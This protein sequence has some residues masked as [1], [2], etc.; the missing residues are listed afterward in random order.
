MTRKLPPLPKPDMNIFMYE[1]FSYQQGDYMGLTNP[2]DK[3]P[4]LPEAYPQ[5]IE[6]KCCQPVKSKVNPNKN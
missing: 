2:N 4:K 6:I 5:L 1:T 3:Y